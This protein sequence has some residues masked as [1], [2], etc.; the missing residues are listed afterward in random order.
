[1]EDDSVIEEM[2]AWDPAV[3]CAEGPAT[4]GAAAAAGGVPLSVSAGDDIGVRVKKGD[5]HSEGNAQW[6]Q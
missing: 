3:G 1:M 4:S 2:R 5:N 6:H